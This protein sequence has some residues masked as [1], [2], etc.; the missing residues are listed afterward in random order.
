MLVIP[1]PELT[2]YQDLYEVEARLGSNDYL[3][4]L[5]W[6]GSRWFIDVLLSDTLEP[7]TEGAPLTLWRPVLVYCTHASRPAGEIML[8]S[9]TE[10]T[11]EA[12][13]A[14]L[15]ARCVLVYVA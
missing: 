13:R 2:D 3:L 10:D 4:R 1:T 15:G 5:A 6:D 8:I 12:Q 7:L 9:S 14:D 11:T